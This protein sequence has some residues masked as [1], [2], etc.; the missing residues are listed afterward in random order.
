MTNDKALEA[1]LLEK[2]QFAP[3]RDFAK[4]AHVSSAS[5]YRKADR[6][7]EKF[8]A[9]F[10]RELDWFKPWKK[11]LDWKP[12]RAKWFVGGKLNVSVNCVDRHLTGA[13]RNKAALI[14]E[15]EPGDQRTLTYRDL[16]REVGKFGNALR[17]L[18]VKKGDRVTLYLPMI[19]ELPIAMLACARIGAIHSVV[20]GGFSAESLRDRINDQGAKV[21]VTADGGWRR[22]N[23]VPLKQIADEALQETPSIENVVVVRRTGTPV[24][25]HEGREHWWHRLMEDAPIPCKP[26]KMD[27]EDPL[28]ILYTSGTTGKPKGIL[29]TTGGYLVGTYATSKWVFDLKDEDVYWCTA[30]I[31]WVTGHS[32]VV[33]GPLANGATCLMYEGAPDT[34]ARDRFWDLIERHGVTILYTAP[35]AIRAF[36][37]WG[38]RVARQAR[39][40]VAA[41]A[42][43]RGRADQSRGVDLV[44]EAHRAREV[45]DRRHV[46]ADRDGHDPDHAAAR[47]HEDAARIRD[48]GLSRD[49][50]E[51]PR[52]A[53]QRGEGRRRLSRDHAPVAGDAAHDLGRRRAVRRRPTGRSGARASTSPATAPSATRT[54]TSGCS[55]AWTTS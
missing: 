9:G 14:W 52:P 20:F 3:P 36:M 43:H 34:P 39:P 24:P 23:V 44:P 35:T 49:R 18:G 55:A 47:H 45:P 4:K 32:Y 48:A 54:G 17:K 8:W 28:Y 38:N 1:L 19:P 7:F 41:A 6:N 16:Y 13:R 27:A 5:V 26:E 15:G 53:G 11:V 25:F 50:G 31:G 40:L 42:R 22:G 37:K 21:L 51:D 12:P 10:A 30:D 46:V 33:Y 29:H 2:R